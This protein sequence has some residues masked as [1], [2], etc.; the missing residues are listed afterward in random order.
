MW[1]GIII[2]S[3]NRGA[4]MPITIRIESRAVAGAEDGFPG[5]EAE[6]AAYILSTCEGL[7]TAL[8]DNGER[9][10]SVDCGE[11]WAMTTTERN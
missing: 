10:V 3:I 6:F 4:A 1:C 8:T 2:V 7:W 9:F 5:I 11:N